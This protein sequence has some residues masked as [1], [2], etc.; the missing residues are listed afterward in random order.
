[1]IYNHCILEKAL[2]KSK[3]LPS[4]IDFVVQYYK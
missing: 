3:P 1:M 4:G 2:G